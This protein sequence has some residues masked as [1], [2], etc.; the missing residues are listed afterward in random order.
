M[1]GESSSVVQFRERKC[2]RCP[3]LCG[4][5]NVIVGIREINV[6]ICKILV[7]MFIYL[8]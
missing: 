7:V 4:C 2:G 3:I 6:V 5:G 8:H 1:S